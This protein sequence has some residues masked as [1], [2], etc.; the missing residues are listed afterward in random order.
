VAGF[1]KWNYIIDRWDLL[2]PS[3]IGPFDKDPD[4][5]SAIPFILLKLYGQKHSAMIQVRFH[6]CYFIKIP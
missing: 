4:E 6:I 5:W 1:D 2:N 3:G